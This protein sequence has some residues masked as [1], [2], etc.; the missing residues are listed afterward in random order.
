[1]LNFI[2][3]IFL[4]WPAILA[5]VILAGIGL[6]KANYR[7]LVAAAIL[8][9]PYSWFLSGFPIVKSPIFLLPV[10]LLASALAVHRDHEMLAWLIA[11]PF[12][13][14]VLFL[15]YSILAQQPA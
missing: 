4:G 7:F 10:V 2:I 12:F 3:G 1:M 5:T 15:F 11:L 6:F 13:L 8:A 14:T 9:F